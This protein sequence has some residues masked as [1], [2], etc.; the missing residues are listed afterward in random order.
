MEQLN[1]IRR[2]RTLIKVGLFTSMIYLLFALLARPDISPI[3]RYRPRPLH[4]SYV[5]FL[6]DSGLG[7]MHDLWSPTLFS[8]PD[9]QGFSAAFLS[10][11]N[12]ATDTARPE[13]GQFTRFL[14][15]P[16]SQP[17]ATAL[18]L[19]HTAEAALTISV[20]KPGSVFKRPGTVAPGVHMQLASDLA[21][22]LIEKPD[23]SELKETAPAGWQRTASITVNPFGLVTHAFIE[24][25]SQPAPPLAPSLIST[26]YRLRF[27]PTDT[28]TQGR[29]DLYSLTGEK[30]E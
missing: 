21:A 9:K 1:Y 2:K 12:F 28:E 15:T 5:P 20:A 6:A 10:S 8:F 19:Q 30:S 3:P 14:D 29:V 18:Q 26:L 16:L 23:L 4:V 22:R 17:A 27:Q 13:T 11:H 25:T 24:P 7:K